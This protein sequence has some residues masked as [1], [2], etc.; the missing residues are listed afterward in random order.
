MI[1]ESDNYSVVPPGL[2]HACS[3]HVQMCDMLL[4]RRSPTDLDAMH[5]TELETQ[6]HNSWTADERQT[7]VLIES[8]GRLTGRAPEAAPRVHAYTPRTQHRFV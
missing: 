3:I 5:Q 1:I 7:D 6:R 4:V 8:L 2:E